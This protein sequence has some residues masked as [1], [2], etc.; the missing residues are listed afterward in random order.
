MKRESQS[1][2]RVERINN[3]SVLARTRRAPIHLRPD[4]A[5]SG[6]TQFETK[7]LPEAP[8]KYARKRECRK[9]SYAG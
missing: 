8:E 5:V 9:M 3:R 2:E 4:C 6:E 1:Y 7:E